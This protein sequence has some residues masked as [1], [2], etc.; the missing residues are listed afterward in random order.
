MNFHR[1]KPVPNAS[2]SKATG[3]APTAQKAPSASAECPFCSP[4]LTSSRDPHDRVLAVGPGVKLLP[5]VGMLTPGHLLITSSNHLLGMSDF[6]RSALA[7]VYSWI[8]RIKVLLDEIFG[9]YLLFE[10]GSSTEG[11]SGACVDHAHIHLLPLADQLG[12][13]LKSD[14]VWTKLAGYSFLAEY[15]K[16]SYAYLG[17]D[18]HHYISPNPCFQSQWIRRRAARVLCRDDWDWSLTQD[19][20]ELKWTLD[21]LASSAFT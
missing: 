15:A 8:A 12:S 7:E 13:E 11:R 6:D 19:A 3:T 5:A 20:N 18:N 2:E 1:S 21:R 16:I 4:H 14:L 10:H 9:R 17:L